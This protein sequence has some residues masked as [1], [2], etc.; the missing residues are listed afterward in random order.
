[1]NRIAL[2]SLIAFLTCPCGS[3]VQ[4]AGTNIVR[5]STEWC[6]VWM[7]DM[8]KNDLPRVLLIGDSI[9]RGYYPAVEK[10]LKGKAYVARVAT[11]KSLGDSALLAEVATFL[12][13][14][15]FDVIHFNN[16][17]HGWGY[18]E[19]D[20]R[21]A[22]P[23]LVRTIRRL[24]PDAKLI[25]ATTTPVQPSGVMNPGPNNDRVKARNAIAAAAVKKAGIPVDDLF[26]LVEAHP[27]YYTP[28]GIHFNESG[29]AVEARQVADEISKLLPAK[30]DATPAH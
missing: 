23:E 9:T 26:S 4:A 25:W 10:N 15:K 17:M 13:E 8:N 27:E 30:A 5:E 18:S 21:R 2:F 12:S 28:G 16:G 14:G 7:P 11:S 1:M 20:Y 6:D 22:F 19:E 3:R 24:A 29:I